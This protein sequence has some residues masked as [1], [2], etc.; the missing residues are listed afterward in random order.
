MYFFFNLKGVLP[1]KTRLDQMSRDNSHNFRRENILFKAKLC[2]KI[3]LILTENFRYC[4]CKLHEIFWQ[5][6]WMFEL[7]ID[8]QP[9]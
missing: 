9:Q 4:P 8:A 5:D 2:G 6:G 7:F 3:K 1:G